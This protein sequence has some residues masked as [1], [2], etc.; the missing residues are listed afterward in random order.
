MTRFLI[1]WYPFCSG[2]LCDRIL[3]LASSICIA[4]MLNMK[5]LIR[6][7]HSDLSAGFTIKN[8]YDYY[9]NPVPFK[10]FIMT[11]TDSI[12]YFQ[13]ENIIQ[14]WGENNIMYWSNINLFSYLIQNQYTKDLVPVDYVKHISNAIHKIFSEIFKINPIVLKN[15]EEKHTYDI[16]IHIRTGDKQIY[17]KDNEIFYKDYITDIFKKIKLGFND[18]NKRIFISSDC[19]LTFEIAN[20]F[21]ETFE[22]NEGCVVHTSDDKKI[23]DEGLHKVLLDL[24]VLSKKCESL[25]IGWNSNFSRIGSLFNTDRKIICYEYE[26]DPNMVKEFP[27]DILCNYFSKGKY[28]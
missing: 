19:L 17:N 21:F 22:Y 10:H 26:N 6:W 8:S 20:D 23:N 12:N 14:D 28:T 7:D 27:K 2:G 9:K 11:N 18:E 24:L 25:Y 5:L 4:D 1:H 3:G 15:L 13:N 16:G